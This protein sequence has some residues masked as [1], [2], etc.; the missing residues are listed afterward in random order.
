[1]LPPFGSDGRDLI[2]GGSPAAWFP[3]V[4]P[5]LAGL[6]LSDRVYARAA[7]SADRASRLS[8]GVHQQL[9]FAAY[10]IKTKGS[11]TFSG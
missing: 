6:A 9:A 7:G 3:T 1:V 10:P 5:F 2:I 8:E 4:E 11:A